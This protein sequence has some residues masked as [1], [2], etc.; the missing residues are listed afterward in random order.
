MRTILAGLTALLI[1]NASIMAQREHK[2]EMVKGQPMY[3]V[4][5]KGD[6]PAIYDPK[7]IAADKAEGLYFD[8]EPL[9]LVM[10]KE[11][12]RAYSTWHLDRHEIVNDRLDGTPLAVTW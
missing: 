7:F 4:L 3:S 6:I 12:G 8:D 2:K 10:G 5:E 1:L 9:M 11:G